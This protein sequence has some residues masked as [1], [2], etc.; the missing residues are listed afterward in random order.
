ML[1]SRVIFQLACPVFFILA[2]PVK[3]AD[4]APVAPDPR[5]KAEVEAV[6]KKAPPPVPEDKLRT[7]N[8]LLL[9]GKKDHG[10]GEHDYP[11]WQKNWTPLVKKLPKVTVD[12]A[13]DWP[14]PEQIKAADLMVC[15]LHPP[16]T[17]EQLKDVDSILERG[18]GVVLVHWAIGPPMEQ[19]EKFGQRF[20]LV[21]TAAGFRHGPIELKLTGGENPVTRGLPA[22][23]QLFDETYFPIHYDQTKVTVIATAEEVWPKGAPTK[24]TF[25]QIWSK[26][27]PK[28]RTYSMIPGHYNWSF[29]DPFFRLL[30]LRGM[31]WAAGEPEQ[32][33]DVL[34]TDGVEYKKE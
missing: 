14:K 5:N 25:P 20:G 26:Q 22:T 29:N 3:G 17:D 28:G 19:A 15:F 21:Y 1:K 18:G 30:L 16:W 23:I 8:I 33:F 34:A 6:L 31:A 13:F 9:A 32:R 7:L 24:T 12:T 10:P 4:P 11:L 2:V 27:L